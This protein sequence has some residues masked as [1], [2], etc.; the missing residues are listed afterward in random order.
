MKVRNFC[1]NWRLSSRFL[2]YFSCCP[3]ENYF[4]NKGMTQWQNLISFTIRRQVVLNEDCI[5]PPPPLIT[6]YSY[7]SL[8]LSSQSNKLSRRNWNHFTRAHTTCTSIH[9]FFCRVPAMAR[10]VWTV[11]HVSQTTKA[12]R[13]NAHAR[14]ASVASAVRMVSHIHVYK[15]L[16]HWFWKSIFKI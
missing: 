6:D 8:I 4:S 2:V 11:E 7:S 3:E 16:T 13:T 12:T 9:S 5:T 1:F 15:V 10:V 14:A